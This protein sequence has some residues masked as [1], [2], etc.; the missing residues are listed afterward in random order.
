MKS[1]MK[2]LTTSKVLKTL[3]INFQYLNIKPK[4]TQK[5]KKHQIK[6]QFYNTNEYST[7]QF[8]KPISKIIN[9]Q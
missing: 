5:G 1:T 7:N 3:P 6:V 2:S 8:T 4:N 9:Y